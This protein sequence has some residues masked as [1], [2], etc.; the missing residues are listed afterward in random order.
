MKWHEELW[1]VKLICP[2]GGTYAW[3][4][5]WHTMESTVFGHPGEPK[6]GPASLLS[7]VTGGNL[8]VTFENQGLSAK[9]VIDRTPGK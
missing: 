4:E 8:G 2:G 6:S 3:S 9:A 5:K 7:K 1:G